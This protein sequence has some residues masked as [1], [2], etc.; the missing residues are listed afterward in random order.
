MAKIKRYLYY[1]VGI[2]IVFTAAYFGTG[3]MLK[4]D[5]VIVPTKTERVQGHYMVFSD[6]GVYT[7]S[8]DIRFLNFRS[9]DNYGMISSN[10]GKPIGITVTGFRVPLFSMYKNIVKVRHEY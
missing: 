10:I 9:S 2:V 8:D 7:C 6:K 1:S 4:E 5:L 3:Y